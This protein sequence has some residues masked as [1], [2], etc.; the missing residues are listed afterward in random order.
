M[1]TMLVRVSVDNSGREKRRNVDGNINEN[2]SI[3]VV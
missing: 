3:H 1:Y 2:S